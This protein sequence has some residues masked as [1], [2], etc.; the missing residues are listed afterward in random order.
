MDYKLI[1]KALNEIF[2]GY[3]E[4]LKF[5][6][7]MK[8]EKTRDVINAYDGYG[9]Q[10]DYNEY[11]RVFKLK[12]VDLCVKLTYRTDSYGCNDFLSSVNFVQPVVKEVITYDEI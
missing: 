5:S 2:N 12:E 3:K 1:N 6:T 10:E 7:F 8:E 4:N 9:K 11:Y